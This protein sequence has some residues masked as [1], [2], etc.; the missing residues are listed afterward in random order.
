ML[1][2]VCLCRNECQAKRYDSCSDEY[3]QGDVLQC[4][5]DQ[6]QECLRWL[7]RNHI[8]SK[9]FSTINKVSLGPTQPFDIPYTRREYC[10]SNCNWHAFVYM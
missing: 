2:I 5:P 4:F 10:L 6:L 8:R 9:N 1:T 7:R 3:D